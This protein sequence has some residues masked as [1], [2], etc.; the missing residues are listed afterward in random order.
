MRIKYSV[1][2]SSPWLRPNEISTAKERTLC[3]FILGFFDI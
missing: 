3:A 2:P 1:L